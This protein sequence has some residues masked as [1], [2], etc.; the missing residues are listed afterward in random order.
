MRAD[1]ANPEDGRQP[2]QGKL[3]PA[4]PS[5][6][7]QH[8]ARRPLILAFACKSHAGSALRVLP[9]F[10]DSC[11]SPHGRTFITLRASALAAG[12]RR[13]PRAL[14]QQ[15]R[16]GD[17]AESAEEFE[18]SVAGPE[19]SEKNGRHRYVVLS[20]IFGRQGLRDAPFKICTLLHP[21]PL[22]AA[23]TI[24]RCLSKNPGIL[25]M[26]ENRVTSQQRTVNPQGWTSL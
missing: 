11:Y 9:P 3:S 17:G 2:R 25:G 26:F 24:H 21:P 23:G 6:D 14:L 20:T 15:H 5:R 8:L 12:Q 16:Q 18:N 1:A 4:L 13:T 7:L 19:L 10:S 22:A